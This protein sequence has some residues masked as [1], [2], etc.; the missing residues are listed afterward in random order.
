VDNDRDADPVTISTAVAATEIAPG[1]SG[2]F[3]FLLCG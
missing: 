2:S 1:V 3:P